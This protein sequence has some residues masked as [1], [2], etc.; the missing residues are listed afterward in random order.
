MLID[1]QS[2]EYQEQIEKLT[3]K[4]RSTEEFA[5]KEKQRFQKVIADQQL[6]L[7]KNNNEIDDLV[8]KEQQ[9]SQMQQDYDNI[10]KENQVIHNENIFLN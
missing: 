10:K 8:L 1:N 2:G 7:N 4:L 9:N 5:M 6:Q 3:I